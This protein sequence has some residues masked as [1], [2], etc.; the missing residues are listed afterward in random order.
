MLNTIKKG[1]RKADM[2][3]Q[4]LGEAADI[5]RCQVPHKTLKIDGSIETGPLPDGRF[6]CLKAVGRHVD[7]QTGFLKISSGLYMDFPKYNK[8]I[9]NY[10]LRPNDI[11]FTFGGTFR[12]V[13]A[14]GIAPEDIPDFVVPGRG[15]CIIRAK[16][17]DPVWLFYHLCDNRAPMSEILYKGAKRGKDCSYF[18]NIS[19]LKD[20]EIPVPSSREVD[21]VNKIHL[22]ICR[23]EEKI[24]DALN[25]IH[26]S[27][28]KIF[29]V[30]R[31]KKL[32]AE[33]ENREP[34]Q[35]LN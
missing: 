25:N 3:G 22:E 2:S 23:E 35:N 12:T 30:F 18:I 32:A 31:L 8:N 5:L 28:K 14:A 17:I 15:Q 21:G 27:R 26:E 9:F 1:I 13:C 7:A 33:T 20:I 16:D 34:R 6:V 4:T 19:H 10:C 29:T 24:R 11:L